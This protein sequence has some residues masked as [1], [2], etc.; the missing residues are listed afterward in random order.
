MTPC[1]ST[2][3]K[4][5]Q[6]LFCIKNPPMIRLIRLSSTFF[7]FLFVQ[8]ISIIT[9]L[10]IIICCFMDSIGI[11]FKSSIIEIRFQNKT[12]T[13]FH[14]SSYIFYNFILFFVLCNCNFF[15]NNTV[16][17]TNQTTASSINFINKS[18]KLI[19]QFNIF[20]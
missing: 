17:I 2:L 5:F 4:P 7:C 14:T 10:S 13:F 11:S 15:I 6:E 18:F 16:T 9:F 1:N 12:L 8:L 19:Y 20:F 3:F